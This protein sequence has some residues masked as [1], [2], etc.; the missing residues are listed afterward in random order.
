M[1]PVQDLTVEDRVSRTQF[2]YSLEDPDAGELN[3]WAPRFVEKL[4]SLPRA[5]RCGQRPADRRSA[6]SLAIDRDTAS[7]LGITAADDR[8]HALRRLRPAAG[9]HDL[10]STEPVPRGARSRAPSFNRIRTRCRSIYVALAN[11]QPGAAE[12]V[13]T[14]RAG[15]HRRW[16]S[17]TRDSFPPSRSPLT[18]RPASLWATP[19]RPSRRPNTTSACR[20]ASRP[21]SREPRRRSRLRWPTSRC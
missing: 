3:I 2:Q 4:Q 9:L 6:G 7:R 21:V 1:Q 13:H 16:P 12:R 10:H 14:L 5:A 11:G 20:A 19:S 18:S 15:Q 8:R 17:I